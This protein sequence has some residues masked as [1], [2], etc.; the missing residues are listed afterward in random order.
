MALNFGL[1]FIQEKSKASKVT[2]RQVDKNGLQRERKREK[3]RERE[4]ERERI[5]E[6]MLKID[7]GFYPLIWMHFHPATSTQ[8]HKS[9]K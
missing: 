9:L 3:E 5:D 2:M 1:P 6:Q 4:R 7:N 8:I